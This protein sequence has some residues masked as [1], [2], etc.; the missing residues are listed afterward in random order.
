MTFC[1][2]RYNNYLV[3]LRIKSRIY[4]VTFALEAQ[5]V[6]VAVAAAVGVTALCSIIIM[7][8]RLQASAVA[9]NHG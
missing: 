6:I 5:R 4:F 3:I 1:V 2:C 8:A 9:W 7:Y